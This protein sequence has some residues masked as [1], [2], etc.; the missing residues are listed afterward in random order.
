M[1]ERLALPSV[2]SFSASK[3]S[4]I[5]SA[6]VIASWVMASRKPRAATGHTSDNIKVMKATRVPRVIWPC[7]AATAPDPEDDDQ[8]DVG[9]DLRGRSR[10]AH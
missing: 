2:M 4:Q 1:L 6:A 5:R 9:D 8:G 3:I 7:P 10:T